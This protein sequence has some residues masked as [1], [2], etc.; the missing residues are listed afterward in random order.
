VKGESLKKREN[1]QIEYCLSV[2]VAA[3]LRMTTFRPCLLSRKISLD[4]SIVKD[5]ELHQIQHV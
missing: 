2:E 4:S 1:S 3:V 5:N